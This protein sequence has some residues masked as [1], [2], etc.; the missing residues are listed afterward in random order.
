MQVQT[1]CRRAGC[2]ASELALVAAKELIDNAFDASPKGVSIVLEDQTLIVHD[3]GPGLSEDQ[4]TRIFNVRRPSLSSKRW[5]LARRGA[6]GNGVR[7]VMGVAHVSG[8]SLAVESRGVELR[9][10]VGPDGSTSVKDRFVSDVTEGTRVSLLFGPMIDGDGSQIQEYAALCQSATGS[11]YGGSKAVP[12]WFDGPAIRELLRDAP[13]GTSAL[14]FVRSFD[15]TEAA[16]ESI[17]AYAA[18][19]TA[20]E[21]LVDE[22]VVNR[23]TEIILAGG[24]QP[25]EL[26]RMGRSAMTGAYA[27]ARTEIRLGG[28]RVPA[29]VECWINGT[30]VENRKTDGEITVFTLFANRTPALMRMGFGSV[31]SS[32]K[33]PSPSVVFPS[34]SGKP[35]RRPA[36]SR[37]TSP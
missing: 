37:S 13:D 33:Y 1:L 12:G 24:K 27:F 16:L 29:I 9:F 18:R 19:K 7:V 34:V 28:A 6:L 8:G 4:A 31:S 5:R 22:I 2:S 15:L 11:A 32:S 3:Q 17:K 35:L 23:L 26:K 30:P 10:S 14:D 21:I 36:A 25:R 20:S